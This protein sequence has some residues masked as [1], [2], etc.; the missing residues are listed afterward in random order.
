MFYMCKK[1]KTL[2]SNFRK[3]FPKNIPQLNNNDKKIHDEF[4]KYWLKELNKKR[5]NLI[6]N[7]NHQYSIKYLLKNNFKKNINTLELGSGIGSH[8]DYED[9]SLQ[10]YYVVDIRENVLNEVKKKNKNINI[11]LSDVQKKC[12]LIMDIL[13]ELMQFIFWN[14]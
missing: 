4:V 8:L 3:K 1:N 7:F 13:I 12:R 2:V 14:T 10:N 5:Y 9:V 11:L 6:E